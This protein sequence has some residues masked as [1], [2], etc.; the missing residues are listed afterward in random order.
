[1]PYTVDFHRGRYPL[2]S[3]IYFGDN[4]DCDRCG[5]ANLPVIFLPA[6]HNAGESYGVVLCEKCLRIIAQELHNFTKTETKT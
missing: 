6:E 2:S 4:D 1:M 5:I 3:E